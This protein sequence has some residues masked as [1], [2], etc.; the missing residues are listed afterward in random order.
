MRKYRGFVIFVFHVYSSR[1]GRKSPP[2]TLKTVIVMQRQ[3]AEQSYIPCSGSWHR[4]PG[5]LNEW[6]QFK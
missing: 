6:T 2:F 4:Q 1:L 5:I 3:R